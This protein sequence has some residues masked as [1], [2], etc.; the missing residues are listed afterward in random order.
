MNLHR[1]HKNLRFIL[2]QVVFV[3]ILLL[4]AASTI[5]VHVLMATENDWYPL[6][7]WAG[8]VDCAYYNDPVY[9]ELK[10]A[11]NE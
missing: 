10:D 1:E 2:L 4:V 5:Y 6:M 11:V 3:A 9:R 8:K 7:E